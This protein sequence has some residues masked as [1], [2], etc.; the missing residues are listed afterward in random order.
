MPE[1]LYAVDVETMYKT[2]APQQIRNMILNGYHKD[3]SGAIQIILN[4]GW[5]DNEGR[6]TGTTHGNWNPYD[7]HIPLLWYGYGINEGETHKVLT[8]K[9][10]SATI[11]AILHIQM[12]SGC[13]G[14]PINEVIKRGN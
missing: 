5:Y 9:D 8:M 11:A 14:T 7:T 3:R 1:V 12:P 2:P 10:I 13:V 6:L 4:A